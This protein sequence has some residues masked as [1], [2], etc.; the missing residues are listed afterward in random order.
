[1]VNTAVLRIVLVTSEKLGFCEHVLRGK[2]FI[3]LARGIAQNEVVHPFEGAPPWAVCEYSV[4]IVVLQG[5]EVV[6]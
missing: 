3:P 1:M 4:C 2:A 6:V 5:V